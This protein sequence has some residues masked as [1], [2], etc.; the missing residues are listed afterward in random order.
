MNKFSIIEGKLLNI[1]ID[2]IKNTYNAENILK[3]LSGD[4]K[5]LFSKYVKTV[6][7]LLRESQRFIDIQTNLTLKETIKQLEEV[8]KQLKDKNDPLYSNYSKEELLP[9][10]EIVY[11]TKYYLEQIPFL[12]RNDIEGM[13]LVNETVEKEWIPRID[14]I[15]PTFENIYNMKI[16]DLKIALL[17]TGNKLDKYLVKELGKISIDFPIKKLNTDLD[18]TLNGENIYTN[19]NTNLHVENLTLDNYLKLEEAK[20]LLENTT[21]ENE[22]KF[23]LEALVNK[24]DK[25]PNLVLKLENKKEINKEIEGLI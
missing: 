14:R 10:E 22:Y 11:A 9:L 23:Y 7:D 20:E 15:I 18:F 4:S 13:R 6:P 16:D 1:K 21:N 19:G 12:L 2:Y 25:N 8:E 3:N 5:K 24:L 17:N